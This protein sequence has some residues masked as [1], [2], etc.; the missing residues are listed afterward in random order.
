MSTKRWFTFRTP[1]LVVRDSI[2]CEVNSVPADALS[3]FA[4]R[5]SAGVSCTYQSLD[6]GIF[7]RLVHPYMTQNNFLIYWNIRNYLGSGHHL[8]KSECQNFE[9]RRFLGHWNLKNVG[10][11]FFIF[12]FWL[13]IACKVFKSENHEKKSFALKKMFFVGYFC[14]EIA[15]N[16]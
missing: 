2:N 7:S 3:E 5:T 8:T 13:E 15:W 10:D 6:D 14:L 4:A 16:M 12:Y 1:T 11:F 9:F